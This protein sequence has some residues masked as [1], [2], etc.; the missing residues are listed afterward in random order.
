MGRYYKRSVKGQLTRWLILTLVTLS[1]IIYVLAGVMFIY[2]R[3]YFKQLTTE[4][5]EKLNIKAYKSQMWSKAGRI[6]MFF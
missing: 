2:G 3:S 6:G 1:L 4:K 5:I